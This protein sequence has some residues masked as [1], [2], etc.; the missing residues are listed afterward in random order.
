MRENIS[1]EL[2]SMHYK[3]LQKDGNLKIFYREE[4]EY[5]KVIMIVSNY[6]MANI[7][8]EQ[9][10][11]DIQKKIPFLDEFSMKDKCKPFMYMTIILNNNKKDMVKI[12][13]KNIMYFI[14]G[15]AKYADHDHCFDEEWKALKEARKETEVIKSYLCRNNKEIRDTN[16]VITYLFILCCIFVFIIRPD[17][18]VYGISWKS[19]KFGN[20]V[21]LI[22]YNFMH[23]GFL[24]LL[25]NCISFLLLG[26]MLEKRIGNLNFLLLTF[27]S[28]MYAGL[29]SA[30][31]KGFT[32]SSSPTIGLSGVVFAVSGALLVYRISRGFD[33]LGIIVYLIFSIVIGWINP[34]IDNAAHLGG[35]ACGI[36]LTMFYFIMGYIRETAMKRKIAVINYKSLKRKDRMVS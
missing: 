32:L 17:A 31:Y 4:K 13:Q 28:G 5:H 12:R 23:T 14:N 26:T 15:H 3:M 7:K 6:G 11:I 16:P 36:M 20:Y 19:L 30:V 2:F 24:H 29:A 27:I 18:Q 21:S 9:N 10:L 1:Q 25:N 34:N 33:Y 8:I 35:L 22:T